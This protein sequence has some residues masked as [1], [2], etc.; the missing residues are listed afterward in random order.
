M[1]AKAYAQAILAGDDDK[2]ALSDALQT[3]LYD[4]VALARQ[5]QQAASQFA[6]FRESFQKWRAVCA[7]LAAKAPERF[8]PE[9]GHVGLYLKG[10]Y[11]LDETLYVLCLTHG[12]FLSHE[13]DA[14]DQQRLAVSGMKLV[15]QER[16]RE[17]QE[18]AR[19]VRELFRKAFFG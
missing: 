5:R 1:K 4:A 19:A 15:A 9:Q 7:E 6:V 2:I 12:V 10:L 14:Q 17:Q 16:A 13:L 18:H 11:I 3:M 8:S